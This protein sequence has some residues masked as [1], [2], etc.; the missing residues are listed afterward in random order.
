VQSVTPAGRCLLVT[1][2]DNFAYCLSPRKGYRVW[3][4]QLPGRVAAQPLVTE[5]GILLAPLSGEEC[6]V[7]AP[8]DGRKLNSINV[9]EDNNTGAS[10][11]LIGRLL[12]VTTRKGLFAYSGT[13][14]WA[15]GAG[16]LL[17]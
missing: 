5:D 12:L 6:V 3:K 8:R 13:E 15:S 9:G 17:K 7:L 10:P 16:R 14:A 11:V 2:L 4:R 1:S